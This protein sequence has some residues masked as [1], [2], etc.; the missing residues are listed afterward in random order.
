MLKHARAR[1]RYFTENDPAV[2][3]TGSPHKASSP[4][5]SGMFPRNSPSSDSHLHLNRARHA[6]AGTQLYHQCHEMVACTW[7]LPYRR[8]NAISRGHRDILD[9]LICACGWDVLETL[10]E[11]HR[12]QCAMWDVDDG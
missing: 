6:E 12:R 9:G 4:H 2:T 10:R 5:L 7:V 11:D 1:Q 3:L 8:C